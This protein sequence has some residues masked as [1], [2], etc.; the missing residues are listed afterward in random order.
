MA[1]EESRPRQS[2]PLLPADRAADGDDLGVNLLG[3]AHQRRPVGGIA[4]IGIR[5]DME[6]AV[7]CMPENHR[8][9]CTALQRPLK[10]TEEIGQRLWRHDDVLDE[11]D[12]AR[13]SADAMERRHEA[14]REI[15][16]HRHIRGILGAADVEA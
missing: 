9:G 8:R 16:E 12:G 7:S 4:R 15:P 10:T 2:E 11:G 14:A 1:G 3:E 6:L 13:H 5:A